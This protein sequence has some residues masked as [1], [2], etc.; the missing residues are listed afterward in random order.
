M[1][2]PV[3]RRPSRRKNTVRPVSHPV[4]SVCT[5]EKDR[6]VAAPTTNAIPTGDATV[7]SSTVDSTRVR[8]PAI[9][10]YTPTGKLMKNPHLHPIPSITN[11]PRVGPIDPATALAAP[12]A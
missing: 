12:N 1:K 10:V 6:V 2:A 4:D 8:R 5:I 7:E 9:S 3:T 11:A